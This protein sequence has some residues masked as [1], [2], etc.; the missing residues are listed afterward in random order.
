[1]KKNKIFFIINPLHSKG[2]KKLKNLI[3][4]KFKSDKYDLNILISEYKGHS[5]KLAKKAV[6]NKANIVVAC[7]GDGTI[8]EVGQSLVNTTVLLGVIP[9][10]SGNGFA[11]HFNIPRNI[12]YALN[13]I[14]ENFSTLIDVGKINKTFFF[15][16]FGLGI[17][18]R[19]IHEYSNK[20]IRGLKGYIISFFKTISLYKKQKIEIEFNNVK[21]IIFPFL[22]LISN[23]SQQ[24]YNFSITPKARAN[25][26]KLELVYSENH[27][28]L[29]LFY[30]LIISLL[31][32][33]KSFQLLK[34]SDLNKI[35]ITKIND[36]SFCLQI[37][38]EILNVSQKKIFLELVPKSLKVIV[39]KKIL[40]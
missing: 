37:D 35:S 11:R 25:N 21:K 6:F 24:G 1:M 9:L 26:G 2:V 12:N 39:P 22:F 31:I 23:T 27:S 34:Y 29:V 20:K 28:L 4:T 19:F 16:N 30:N 3:K 8:N 36:A 10:G 18:A 7:G 13:I 32:K 40:N 17:E 5:I 15:S 38:G 33:I 14:S